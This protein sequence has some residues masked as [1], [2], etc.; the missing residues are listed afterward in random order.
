MIPLDE[1]SALRR[2]LYL[3]I[4][5]N[6]EAGIMRPAGF[7]TAIPACKQPQTNALDRAAT[8]VGQNRRSQGKK[9]PISGKSD[10]G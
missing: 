6:K 1:C 10:V 8:G 7:E 4:H 3:K 5:N 9:I 2:G